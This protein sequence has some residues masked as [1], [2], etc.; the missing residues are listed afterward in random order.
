[1]LTFF[2][3]FLDGI[4]SICKAYRQTG[5][6]PDNLES[7]QTTLKVPG[8]YK[9]LSDNLKTFQTILKVIIQ[10][11]K[12]ER[13]HDFCLAPEVAWFFFARQVAW[14]FFG[15]RG[16]IISFLAWEVAWFFFFDLE[17]AW[18]FGWLER[19]PYFFGQRG[20]IIFF[21]LKSCVIFFWP[22][23]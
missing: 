10:S 18:F 9:I 16:D 17:V 11:G 3:L 2:S 14:F 12:F 4:A 5:N 13:L 8:Q 19:M 15:P 21:G 23:R 6:F 22:E 1:M 20:C 7:F